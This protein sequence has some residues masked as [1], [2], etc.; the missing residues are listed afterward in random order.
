MYKVVSYGKEYTVV[1]SDDRHETININNNDIL[2]LLLP[3]YAF[4][5]HKSQGKTLDNVTIHEFDLMSKSNIGP[6]LKYTACSRVRNANDL[7]IYK[8]PIDFNKLNAIKHRYKTV[9]DKNLLKS[10]VNSKIKSHKEDRKSTR[11]NSSHSQQ[12]RM[13]SSA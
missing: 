11:L 9:K 8:G 1:K 13:P 12:S 3:A 4:T 5:T 6:Q 7:K 10:K 2:K